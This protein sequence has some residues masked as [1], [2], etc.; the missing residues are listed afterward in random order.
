MKEGF[1]FQV[2][3]NGELPRGHWHLRTKIKPKGGERLLEFAGAND[4]VDQLF[5]IS[6]LRYFYREGLEPYLEVHPEDSKAGMYSQFFKK[7]R[8]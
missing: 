1:K 2:L 8:D 4:L 7:A 5:L 6:V 3:S